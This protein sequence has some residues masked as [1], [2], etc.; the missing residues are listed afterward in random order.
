M[1]RNDLIEH[2]ELNR[3]E[4][5][6]EDVVFYE[7][8]SKVLRMRKGYRMYYKKKQ[9]WK[10]GFYH[11]PN[12]PGYVIN[13]K[14][15][16]FSLAGSF[17]RELSVKAWKDSYPAVSIYDPDKKKYRRVY[18]HMLIALTF[19]ENEDYANKIFVNHIDGNK[20]NY[21][22]KNLEW[23]N[24]VGN[25]RHMVEAGLSS[26][27][28]PCLV[29]D[30][31]NGKVYKF[32]SLS[33]AC[34]ELDIKRSSNMIFWKD[35]KRISLPIQGRFEFKFE[36]MEKEWYYDT[37]QIFKPRNGGKVEWRKV[38]TNETGI[39]ESMNKF[40][41]QNGID[42]KV[43]TSMINTNGRKIVKGFVLRSFNDNTPSEWPSDVFVERDQPTREFRICKDG[44]TK[45]FHSLN[46]L[47]RF[48]KIEPITVLRR[49]K[50]FGIIEGWEI[51]EI[52][53]S[54]L[55]ERGV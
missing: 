23:V 47:A 48:F 51:N 41:K 3:I 55:P 15:V 25:N 7:V 53:K 42:R 50:K 31:S 45:Y 20:H 27:N 2:F 52:K 11:I 12:F 10:E 30:H 18:L 13:G 44:E 17:P 14:G 19:V 40:S 32:P 34:R 43:V 4:I 28:Y 24:S 21:A 33:F 35:G 38:G 8:N 16:L 6:L 9:E 54:A 22:V 26:Q 46:S 1:K 37:H 36:G 5:N 29:K 39:V 49:M